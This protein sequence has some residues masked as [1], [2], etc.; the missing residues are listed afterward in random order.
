MFIAEIGQLGAIPTGTRP[1]RTATVSSACPSAGFSSHTPA[2][3]LQVPFDKLATMNA[4]QYRNPYGSYAP[5]SPKASKGD[6]LAKLV[7]WYHGR[8]YKEQGILGGIA[9][10]IVSTR[11]FAQSVRSYALS[12]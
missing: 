2:P 7:A 5:D 11:H 12:P 8:S 10:F 4:S 9:A 1:A 3:T 6:P